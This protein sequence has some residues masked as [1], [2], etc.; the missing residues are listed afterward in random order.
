MRAT[1]TIS[2]PQAAKELLVQPPDVR[3]GYTN[4]RLEIQG[5]RA[6]D[7]ILL[8]P[9]SGLLL[10]RVQPGGDWQYGDRVQLQ[11][12]LETPPENEEFSYRDYLARQGIYAYMGQSRS[13]LLYRGQGS[14]ILAAL[15]GF[16]QRALAMV[17]RLYPDPEASLLAG[18]LLGVESGIPA[19]VQQAFK[20]TGTSHII[21]ISG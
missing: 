2:V 15:Y 21:A 4:L 7:D 9:V 17:Y 8:T 18:I 14:P 16:K 5:I 20:D 3:D 10:A 6:L 11:G 13:R 19:S 12:H 1:V